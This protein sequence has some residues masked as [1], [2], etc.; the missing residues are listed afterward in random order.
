MG[1]FDPKKLLA[2]LA[3]LAL[4][5]FGITKSDIFSPEVDQ[6]LSQPITAKLSLL[7]GVLVA[8]AA[9]VLYIGDAYVSR[10]RAA[11]S[12]REAAARAAAS[13]REA[14]ASERE[15]GLRDQIKKSN[16][17]YDLKLHVKSQ[18]VDTLLQQI[19]DK[20]R[21]RLLDIVT[22]IPNQ[23]KW[24][25]DVKDLSKSDDPDPHYQMVMIDLDNFREI[26]KV[27]GYEKGDQVIKEFARTIFNSMR[28]DEHIYKN[29]AR[30]E[31]GRDLTA[32]SPT[33]KEQIYRKYTGG[34]E[35]ILMI[36]GDQAEALGL[37]TR[38]LRD[39][40]PKI[41]DRVSKFILNSELTLSFHAGM[42]EWVLGDEPQDVLMRL[43]GTL[44]KAINSPASRLYY[45]PEITGDEFE[46]QVL[47]STG[48][49]PRWNPYRD[50]ERIFAKV[51]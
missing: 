49:P 6:F 33:A 40:M 51:R 30:E 14:A 37:L 48:K 12:E 42:C 4:A 24:E 17:D 8:Y 5:L 19:R 27:Y 25:K 31:D 22:G 10:A 50:A 21:L 16:D 28:R 7:V 29:L 44:R 26:N 39:L 38:L 41:N 46:R 36:N 18:E 34:D 3:A 15:K 23:L 2:L 43:E 45:Y 9:I 20:D 32:K 11:A 13:E 35:F 47:Q 1:T